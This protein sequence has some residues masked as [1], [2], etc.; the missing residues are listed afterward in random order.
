MDD[1]DE[2]DLARAF[3]VG[4]L[5]T[6]DGRVHRDDLIGVL[7][8]ADANELGRGSGIGLLRLIGSSRRG[9]QERNE[10]GESHDRWKSQYVDAA[11]FGEVVVHGLSCREDRERIGKVD[12]SFPSIGSP[13]SA[14]KRR[15]PGSSDDA[16]WATMDRCQEGAGWHVWYLPERAIS[17]IMVADNERP[18]TRRPKV[19][20]AV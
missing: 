3:L 19:G 16:A 5:V 14:A 18:W 11:R 20:R 12:L 4:E 6:R 8:I 15:R 17:G 13:E 10:A 2:V 9:Q 7:R 1:S